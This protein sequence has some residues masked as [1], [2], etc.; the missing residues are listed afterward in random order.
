[1]E[2]GNTVSDDQ[3]MDRIQSSPT[4]GNVLKAMD[5]VFGASNWSIDEVWPGDLANDFIMRVSI[6]AI[7]G[8]AYII[9]GRTH[10]SG[11]D[12]WGPYGFMSIGVPDHTAYSILPDKQHASS[13]NEIY[14]TSEEKEQF[15]FGASGKD[16]NDMMNFLIL[17][18]RYLAN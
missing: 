2:G 6:N 18:R 15:R 11:R 10:M 17:L 12:S 4:Y 1:M 16:I 7:K 14:G 9:V 13:L 8:A 5:Q 3:V